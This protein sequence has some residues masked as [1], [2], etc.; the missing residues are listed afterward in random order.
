MR[1]PIMKNILQDFSWKDTTS[2]HEYIENNY[3]TNEEC[4]EVKN[5]C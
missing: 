4:H 2:K 3:S 1:E 5:Y